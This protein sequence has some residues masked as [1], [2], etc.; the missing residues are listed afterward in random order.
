[1]FA[2]ITP[3][4]FAVIAVQ[5]GMNC[6]DPKG[7]PRNCT[8]KDVKI[9]HYQEVATLRRGTA[10]LPQ[11]GVIAFEVN[12]TTRSTARATLA[13]ANLSRSLS[14]DAFLSSLRSKENTYLKFVGAVKNN[15]FCSGKTFSCPVAP[16]QQQ[17]AAPL[18][19]QKYT[20]SEHGFLMV[21][22]LHDTFNPI[23]IADRGHSR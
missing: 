13:Y 21:S 10:P 6:G 9:I 14:S 12:L 1:M 16:A 20:Y 11:P 8:D 7:A 5:A 3:P 18:Q 4:L 22:A 2:F 23:S 17:Q 15:M 19:V